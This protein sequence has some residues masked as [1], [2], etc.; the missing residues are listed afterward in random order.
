MEMRKLDKKIKFSG[1]LKKRFFL[2]FVAFLTL[3]GMA[4]AQEWKV[5]GIVRDAKSGE[6]MPFVNVGLMRP[7]D[8]VF[9][10]GAATDLSGHFEI[11]GVKPGTYLLQ[12]SFVGYQTHLEQ[13]EVLAQLDKLELTLTP[14]TLLE[15]VKIVA[16]RPLYAMDGEKNMYNA[17]EE[18]IYVS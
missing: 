11:T 4:S 3:S 17:K 1:N 7:A 16:E 14:G 18:K 9:V 8:T 10:R 2:L 15:E 5:S 12:A 6:A 13:L